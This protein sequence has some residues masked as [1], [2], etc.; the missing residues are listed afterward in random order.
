MS[1][2]RVAVF[3]Q[4]NSGAPIKR[5]F[6]VR[7]Q[8]YDGGRETKP[9]SYRRA[10]VDGGLLGV[11]APNTPRVWLGQVWGQDTASGTA[12]DGVEEI[13]YGTIADLKLAWA[14]GDLQVKS[15]EDAAY[16]SCEWKG[17]WGPILEF[18]P[19]RKHAIVT[20]T[21]EGKS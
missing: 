6:K 3:L 9:A 19:F 15:F 7:Q 12:N 8:D 2:T 20:M 16:W 13:E 1:F 5:A 4:W 21:L 17:D 11:Y 10:L 18:D 14:A